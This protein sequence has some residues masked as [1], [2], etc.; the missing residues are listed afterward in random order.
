MR[1]SRLWLVEVI[2]LYHNM[3]NIVLTAKDN[4][5]SVLWEEELLRVTPIG[6]NYIITHGD[7]VLHDDAN[8][9]D[10][11]QLITDLTDKTP[12]FTTGRNKEKEVVSVLSPNNYI[13]ALESLGFEPSVDFLMGGTTSSYLILV[14]CKPRANPVYYTIP[15]IKIFIYSILCYTCKIKFSIIW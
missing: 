4:I 13:K 5:W 15:V 1:E 9:F 10:M 7:K 8:M 6:V 12:L 11:I 14:L 3:N 2:L